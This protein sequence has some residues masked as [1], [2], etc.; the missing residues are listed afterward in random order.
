MVRKVQLFLLF[1]DY[2]VAVGGG[3]LQS[4]LPPAC[5]CLMLGIFAFLRNV[6]S[7]L[8]VFI[9]DLFGHGV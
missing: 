7:S 1:E 6:K 5:V 2:E 4:D 8:E 3:S 9:L